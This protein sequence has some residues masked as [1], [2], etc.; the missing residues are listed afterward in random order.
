[1][2]LGGRD[3]AR[4]LKKPG[5]D[6]AGCLLYGPDPVRTGL[7]RRDLVT[8][9]VGPKGAEEMRLTRFQ[10]GDL[11]R[12]PAALT[13]ALKATGFFPGPRAVVVED[14]GDSNTAAV[15]AALEDWRPGDATLVLSAGSLT[16]RSSLRKAMEA[17]KNAFAIAI[18]ADP[19]RRDEIEA[20]LARESLSSI[21]PEAMTDLEALAQSLDPGDF[22][23]ILVKL[24]LYMRG[25]PGPV[26]SDDIAAVAPP[27]AEAE[28]TALVDLAADGRSREL[29]RAFA[30]LSPSAS[31]T[32]LTILAARHFRT[33][34][35]ASIDPGGADT[36]L[37]RARPPVF[38][39]RRSRMAAQ[40]RAFGTERLEN[41]LGQIMEA[42]LR[43]RSGRPTPG[44]A[45]VERLFVR[46]AYLARR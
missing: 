19:M 7:R 24:S 33:L 15:R 42:E 43:L 39:P 1:M 11:R 22:E 28:L 34:H 9:L 36:A 23:Q 14:A 38:G 29:A 45:L 8:A 26:S 6:S 18:Y 30:A 25:A 41:A 31:A 37:A 12:D 5:S 16:P 32:G 46:I 20:A 3:A 21:S 40:I 4:Y 17:A 10:G 27:A 35:A 44:L 13:D 2:K